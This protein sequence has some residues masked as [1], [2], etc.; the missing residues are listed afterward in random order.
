MEGDYQI[1]ALS[2]PR[3][4]GAA[5]APRGRAR[6]ASRRCQIRALW[7]RVPLAS[8]GFGMARLHRRL[9]VAG[10]LC[11]FGSA[12]F[13]QSIEAPAG[14]DPTLSAPPKAH[15]RKSVHKNATAQQS[16]ADAEKAARL[17]EGRRKFFQQSMGFDNGKSGDS[18]ITFTGGAGL[19]PSAGFKF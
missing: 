2:P 6:G 17:E 9:L 8:E 11:A 14:A 5:R 19:S 12:A 13:A 7:L 1:A 3:W 16:A 15:A 18:P 10:W 4:R